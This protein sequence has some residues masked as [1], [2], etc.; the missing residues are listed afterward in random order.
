MV[1][2]INDESRKQSGLHDGKKSKIFGDHKI[3]FGIDLK[4]QNNQEKNNKWN[5]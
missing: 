1:D 2:Q 4:E 3:M 5:G